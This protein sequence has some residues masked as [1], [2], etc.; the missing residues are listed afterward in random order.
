L[1]TCSTRHN[2][3]RDANRSAKVH[4]GASPVDDHAA[5]RALGDLPVFRYLTDG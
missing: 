2:L 4:D 1:K 3:R 5:H